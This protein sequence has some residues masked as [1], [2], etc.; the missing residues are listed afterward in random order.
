MMA[1]LFFQTFSSHKYYNLTILH[2]G[3]NGYWD[4]LYNHTKH[5]Y[6]SNDAHLMSSVN[7]PIVM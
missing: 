5:V 7:I 2:D 1:S 3:T 6:L 4:E